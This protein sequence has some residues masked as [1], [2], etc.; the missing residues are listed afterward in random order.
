MRF[1]PRTRYAL[2]SM[3][4]L[5]MADG[6]SLPMSLYVFSANHG[7]SLSYLEQIFALLKRAGL[8]MGVRGPGG[9]YHLSRSPSQIPLHEIVEAVE[10]CAEGTNSRMRSERICDDFER[11]VHRAILDIS[12]ADL[13]AASERAD[14]SLPRFRVGDAVSGVAR[15][16]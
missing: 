1:E 6:G 14:L 13:I 3:L 11:R 4:D 10:G 8:V 2:A 15:G 9:G 5:A 7:I 16:V 12:L